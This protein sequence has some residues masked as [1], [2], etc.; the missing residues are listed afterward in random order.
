[1]PRHRR[2]ARA[3][4]HHQVLAPHGALQPRRQRAPV[5]HGLPLRRHLR[6]RGGVHLPHPVRVRPHHHARH[7]R[8]DA[9]RDPVDRRQRVREAGM[10]VRRRR[11]QHDQPP[12]HAQRMSQPGHEQHLPRALQ[13]LVQHRAKDGARARP[14][15]VPADDDDGR[16]RLR[17]AA[18]D[19]R[20]DVGVHPRHGAH[21]HL[22]GCG[23]AHG[24]GQHLLRLGHPRLRGVPLVRRHAQRD[25]A[26][27]PCRGRGR[28][29]PGPSAPPPSPGWPGG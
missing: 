5:L 7:P 11:H 29:R 25:T 22:R 23:V 27:R 28:R 24:A 17:H 26:A 6:A 16:A 1:M 15:P 3:H 8:A 12:R 13:Q 2:P 10:P 14:P 19:P 20:R 4:Q 9:G 21:G 18:R